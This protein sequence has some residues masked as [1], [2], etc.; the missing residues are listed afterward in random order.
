MPIPA[1]GCL[2]TA[3]AGGVVV[4]ILLRRESSLMAGEPFT[5]DRRADL[6]NCGSEIEGAAKTGSAL[7]GEED[8]KACRVVLDDAEALEA[9]RS[10][11][12]ASAAA[13]AALAR[14]F[15]LS[16]KLLAGL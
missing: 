16:W 1:E 4:L 2:C 15:N 11:P 9:D 5:G 3:M 8:S 6:T 13:A 7:L 12:V 10:R 14:S